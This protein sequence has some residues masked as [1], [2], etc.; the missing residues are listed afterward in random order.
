MQLLDEAAAEYDLIVLDAP[1]LLG[2]AEPLEMA[3]AVDGV[4]VVTRAGRTTRKAV[5][6]VLATLTPGSGQTLSESF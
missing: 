3:A 5:S 6:S 2:F 1:P 4:I